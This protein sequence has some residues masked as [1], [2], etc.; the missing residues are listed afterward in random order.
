VPATITL[1]GSSA[2]LASGGS[3]RTLSATV[4]DAD[5]NPVPGRVVAF[6]QR[7]GSG[8]VSGLGNATTDALGA[9]T[10]AVTGD[11]AGSVTVDA[12]VASLHDTLSFTVV[13]GVLDHVALT[14]ASASIS[15]GEFQSYTT[16]AF[17]AAGNTIGDVSSSAT[18]SISL[19]GTC[20]ATSCTALVDGSYT[21]TSTY[22][23]ETD[24]AELDVSGP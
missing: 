11:E 15:P 10:A 21:V 23:G 20:L 24:T 8:S 9:A 7:G 16:I 2:D 19:G 6:S 14:P 3:A 4:R 22:S 18:L 13:P 12:G 1:T 17:D 5:G